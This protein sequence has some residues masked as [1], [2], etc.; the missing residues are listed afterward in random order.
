MNE[1]DKKEI[2]HLKGVVMNKKNEPYGGYPRWNKVKPPPSIL[3][4]LFKEMDENITF[5]DVTPEPENEV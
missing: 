1:E 4:E 5:I 3:E 2:A